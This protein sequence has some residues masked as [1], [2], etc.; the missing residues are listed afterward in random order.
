MRKLKTQINLS[1]FLSAMF[2]LVFLVTGII[3]GF[4]GLILV[5]SGFIRERSPLVFIWILM[6]VSI[7]IGT[8]LSRIG[9]PIL[10]RSTRE[11]IE[12]INALAKGD[13][14][15]RLDVKRP[16]EFVELS[17]SF[18]KMAIE[19]GAIEMLRTDFIN[20]FSHEFKTPIVSIKGFAELLKEPNLSE[21]DKHEYLAII[22]SESQRLT[23]LATN[24]LNL[25][26]VENVGIIT[27][28]ENYNLSE[29]LR[30]SVALLEP[31]LSLKDINLHIDLKDVFVLGNRNLMNQ[32]WLNLLDNAIKFSNVGG[33]ISIAITES[34][35][36]ITV[37]LS[38]NGCG[39]ADTS[40]IYDKFYK[41]D[42][43][44]SLP[45]NGLGL[46]IA[47]RIVELHHGSIYCESVLGEGS[48]FIITLPS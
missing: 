31:R 12:A 1:I 33:S 16:S 29:Q 8:V 40:K 21:V 15:A 7:V 26:S 24:V 35:D 42:T 30:Q 9:S 34:N 32:V 10:L 39:M 44:T 18:N 46:S 27:D 4:V 6:T 13:F 45:G 5:R 3:V 22:I 43:G 2:F 17:E 19:L 47:K 48:T 11:I 23:E 38:D 14:S 20:Q 28:L 36:V 41:L 37:S 25:S